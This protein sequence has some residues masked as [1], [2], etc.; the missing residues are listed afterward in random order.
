M[1]H[2]IAT[3]LWFRYCD[4]LLEGFCMVE[5]EFVRRYREMGDRSGATAVVAMVKGVL[6]VRPPCCA[7]CMWGAFRLRS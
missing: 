6:R 5:Q 7:V 2:C 4:S 3:C 1:A